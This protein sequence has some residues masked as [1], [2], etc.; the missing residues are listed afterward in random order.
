MNKTKEVWFIVGSQDLYG[1]EVLKTVY[2]RANE[3]ARFINNYAAMPV[4]FVFKCVIESTD[5]CTDIM[6]KAN[7]DDKCIGVVTWCHTFS[8]SK[9][10]INGLKLLQKPW[11]HL[12]TQYHKE[13]PNKE[14]DMDFM[15]LNQAAHGD[16]EHGFIGARLRK[17]RKIIAGYYKEK[18][19]L[20][21]LCNWVRAAL[22]YA[23]SQNLKVCRFGDNMRDVAV[24]E[25]DKI[26]AQ[27]QLGWQVNTWPVYEL[28]HILDKVTDKEVDALLSQYK[29][30]YTLAK[31]I[32]LENV[33]YQAKE[34][35]AMRKMLDKIGA[36]AFVNT[37]Q[38]LG[39]LKCLPGLATQDLMAQGYGYGGEGDWKTSAMVRIIKVMTQGLPGGTSFMEDYSYNLPK[40]KQWSLGSHMLEVCPSLANAKPIIKTS[41]LTIGKNPMDPARI[42]YEGKAGKAVVVS[43]IDMGGRFRII[44][45]DVEAIKP[46]LALPNLPTARVVWKPMPNLLDGLKAWILAGGAHHTV[47]SYAANADMIKDFADMC[48]IEFV[49]ISKDT[50]LDCL[51]TNLELY[52]R[53]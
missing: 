53:K 40:N 7:Y 12:A 9:M 46:P 44:C 25:G 17:P 50:C 42:V 38:D 18:E 37:F 51:K 23:E 36:K 5:G 11:C 26:E 45:Q 33:K 21:E 4:D 49:H 20:D 3:M 35:I 24:T 13:V 41:K 32:K 22:G 48:G 30:K 29:A 19:V 10:W 47:F 8:P 27:I 31:G 34:E 43:L 14:M 15:N 2:N 1:R 6:K 28:T 52:D 16:R 39:D